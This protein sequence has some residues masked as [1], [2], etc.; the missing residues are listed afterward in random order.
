MPTGQR[1][2]ESTLT[3]P[4][5]NT[6]VRGV[7]VRDRHGVRG[8]FASERVTISSRS[9]ADL[10]TW[11]FLVRTTVQRRARARAYAWRPS[12][13]EKAECTTE[14]KISELLQLLFRFYFYYSRPLQLFNNF[15]YSR[16]IDLAQPQASRSGAPNTSPALLLSRCALLGDR[17]V[18]RVRNQTLPLHTSARKAS[19]RLAALGARAR[20]RWRPRRGGARRRGGSLGRLRLPFGAR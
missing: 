10:W 8:R 14:R 1:P 13:R 16:S 9:E 18:W 6:V 4:S 7:L 17:G 19:S 20:P 2:Q 15:V 11:T 5:R 3:S 12:V